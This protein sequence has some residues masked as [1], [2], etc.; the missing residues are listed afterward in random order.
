MGNRAM[1]IGK[2][3]WDESQDAVVAMYVHWYCQADLEDWLRICKE[4]EYRSP[5]NH[6]AYGI[7]RLCQVACEDNPDGLNI[8]ME[9]I[10]KDWHPWTDCLLD[11]GFIFI[12]DW[13]IVDKMLSFPDDEED[14]E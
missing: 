9:V 6:P 10:H 11:V 12:D 3:E 1:I 5:K 4:R 8:G 7:A 14:D 2:R 13:E